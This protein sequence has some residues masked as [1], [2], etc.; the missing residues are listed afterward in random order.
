M[1]TAIS[2]C[3][4][5]TDRRFASIGAHQRGKAVGSKNRVSKSASQKPLTAEVSVKQS[6]NRQL[7]TT[8]VGAVKQGTHIH[9]PTAKVK[10][11]FA[12]HENLDVINMTY[13]KT[14]C[15]G[16]ASK[17]AQKLNLKV[18]FYK[19]RQRL[20]RS[21]GACSLATVFQAN[22]MNEKTSKQ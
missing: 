13:L 12:A 11:A 16:F 3:S 4:G 10:S 8:H 14:N 17:S 2:L 18:K 21:G 9:Q 15:F 19:I 7:P 5:A 22:T 1:R 6:I 20:R